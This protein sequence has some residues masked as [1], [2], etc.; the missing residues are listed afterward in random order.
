MT[1][2]KP[3]IDRQLADSFKLLAVQQPIEKIT[4]KDI[5]DGAGLIR[6]TFY[7][8]FQDKYS[9]IRWIIERDLLDPVRPLIGVGMIDAAIELFLTNMMREQEF[10]TQAVKME[11]QNSFCELTEDC[12]REL[13]SEILQG[14]MQGNAEFPWISEEIVA[15]YYAQSMCHIIFT[16][17]ETGMLVPPTEM[18]RIHNYLLTH[19]LGDFLP[20]YPQTN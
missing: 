14:K 19:S 18:V 13:L 3:E 7:H 9:L 2:K 15:R 8:H 20:I 4:I 1:Q 12:L 11:G 5:T 17:V 16:W 6:P 10:Y